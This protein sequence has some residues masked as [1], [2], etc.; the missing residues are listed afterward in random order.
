MKKYAE[1]VSKY[2]TGYEKN[3]VCFMNKSMNGKAGAYQPN[4]FTFD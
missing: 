3:Y 2:P 4:T 1:A